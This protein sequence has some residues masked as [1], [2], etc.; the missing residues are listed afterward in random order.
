MLSDDPASLSLCLVLV[1][2]T[3]AHVLM[4]QRSAQSARQGIRILVYS[5]VHKVL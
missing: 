3:V 1:A 5:V 4:C 2:D